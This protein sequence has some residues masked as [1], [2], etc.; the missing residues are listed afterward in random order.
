[1]LAF[2][3]FLSFGIIIFT[4]TALASFDVVS[5]GYYIFYYIVMGAAWL[6]LGVFGLFVFLGISWADDVVGNHNK[7]AL[8]AFSG[9]FLACA[10]IYAGANIG[11]GPGWWCVI[12]A[13]GL[14]MGSL[15]GLGMIVRVVTRVS[16]RITIGR[17]RGAG[18]RFGVYL[19]AC[20]IIL[21]K[22][23]GGDWTSASMT[24]SEFSVAWPVLPVTA[25]VI[26]IEFIASKIGV[27]TREEKRVPFKSILLGLLY[28]LAALYIVYQ[29]PPMPE[30]PVYGFADVEVLL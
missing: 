4:L 22:A 12:F 20:G 27:E 5:D 16:E 6:H 10:L 11:D 30:N 9:G 19:L 24:I 28:V 18:I 13:G 23:C 14:G 17:D 8:T 15:F 7:A 2:L 29:M 21:A 25:L 3:S 1:V 26:I